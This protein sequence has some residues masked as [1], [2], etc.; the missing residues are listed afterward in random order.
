[1]WRNTLRAGRKRSLPHLFPSIR[2]RSRNP[3]NWRKTNPSSRTRYRLWSL[4]QRGHDSPRQITFSQEKSMKGRSHRDRDDGEEEK[5][6]E[7]RGE[8]R[9]ARETM[10]TAAKYRDAYFYMPVILVTSTATCLF[11]NK[12]RSAPLRSQGRN[13]KRDVASVRWS[14]ICTSAMIVNQ[15]SEAIY[16]Q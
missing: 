13:E 16:S 6:G 4:N 7:W 10:A 5:E 11:K 9:K 2:R 14:I 8:R 12:L 15:I 3:A 1:M